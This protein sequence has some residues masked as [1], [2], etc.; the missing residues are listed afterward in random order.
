MVTFAKTNFNTIV[1]AASRP[2]Y[3]QVLYD[4][5]L[6]LT[7]QSPDAKFERRRP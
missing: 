7:R 1:Y 4:F 3:P 2:T 5:I 6:D